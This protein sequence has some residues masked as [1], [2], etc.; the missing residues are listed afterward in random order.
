MV[1]FLFLLALSCKKTEIDVD[2]LTDFP[3]GILS[4]FPADGNKVVAGNFNITVVFADGTISPL[5]SGSI[6]LK[7]A[8]GAELGSVSGNLSGTEDQLV[9]DSLAFG[10]A[11]LALGFY[12][13]EI[14]VTDSKGQSTDRITTF[15]ISNLPF[16]AVQN[17]LYLAGSYNGWGA[18]ALTLI[19]DN[20]WMATDLMLDG[21]E[22]KL[23]NCVDWCD[24]D[25]GDAACSGIVVN[26][27]GGGANSACSPSGLYNLTFRDDDLTYFFAPA[28]FFESN[29]MSLYLLGSFNDFQGEEYM[30]TQTGDYTWE[31][32][33]ILLSPDDQ[34]RFSEGPFFMG[35]NYGDNEGDGVAEEFGSNIVFAE[36]EAFYN[37]VF[38]DRTLEYTI[39][40]VRF[41]SIGIIGTAT[42]G[43]WDEDTDL[44]DNGDGT[45]S[46]FI[47]LTD[48]VAKFR[49]NDDWPTNWGGTDFPTGIG[50]QDGPDIPITAGVYDITFVPETGE[51]NFASNLSVGIIGDATPSGWAEDT[52]MNSNG[53]GTYWLVAG[54]KTGLVKFRGNDDWP[55]N[56]GAP[57]WP[58][59]T[60]VQDGDN[61]PAQE[62]IYYITFNAG[63]GEY[64]FE[65]MSIGIIGSAIGSWDTDLD[66]AINPANPPELILDINAVDGVVKFRADD[67]WPINWG[68]SD[69]PMGTGV[70]DGP[71]IPVPAGAYTVYFDVNTGEYRFE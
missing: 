40:F 71:D 21:G 18:D 56:W 46:L 53:D 7:D 65:P 11:D 27:T 14:S 58:S 64:N 43:G 33:E 10:A 26:T 16:A 8:G 29:L 55:I 54:L 15:E 61:I 13:L 25:W 57:D 62:G 42:P 49:A 12:T 44:T 37:I 48:G 28:I 1:F 20:T 60:G 6:V 32:E 9:L 38:D 5:A 63:T 50:V 34:F 35:T 19:A 3:P 69:F 51:Y 24:Q 41:P 17:E 36:T 45:F 47:T 39:T 68:A 66:M 52:D 2:A 30:F 59:G 67:D 22:W 23:K 31:L 70:Q 4:V